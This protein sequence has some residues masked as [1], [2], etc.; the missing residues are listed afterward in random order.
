MPKK[1]SGEIGHGVDPL[2]SL[3]TYLS[4]FQHLSPDEKEVIKPLISFQ[5]VSKNTHLQEIGYTCK[6]IYFIKSGIARIYYFK[7]T[8]EVTELFASEGDIIA[9]VE[10]LFTG[11]PSKK[12]IQ[13]IEDSEIMSINAPGLTALY[14]THHGIERLFRKV[15]ESGYL[16]TVLR[17]ESLQFH[18]AEERYQMLIQ[19]TPSL[20]QRVPLKYIASY[21]GIT[22]TSLSRIRAKW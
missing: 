5:K 11:R 1:L 7:D 19:K 2:L 20:V 21:L 22:Q 17:L 4:G 14:D 8:T 13:I 16:E 12:G 10:S 9:R 18:A 3:W 15:F 6:T